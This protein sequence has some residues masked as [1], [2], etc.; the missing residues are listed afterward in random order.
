ML[1]LC[2]EYFAQEEMIYSTSTE[3]LTPKTYDAMAYEVNPNG[4]GHACECIADILEGMKYT[5]W[6]P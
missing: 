2:T 1:Y 5:E 6:T 4:D 3:L